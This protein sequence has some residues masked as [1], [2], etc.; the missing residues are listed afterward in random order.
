MLDRRAD[1]IVSGGENVSPAEVEAV[2]REHPDVADLGVA[3][4]PDPD[5]GSRVAA[6]IV[7][8]AGAPRRAEDLERFCRRRL[9]GFKVP[10]EFHFGDALPRNSSGKL[11]RRQLPRLGWEEPTPQPDPD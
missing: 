3:A 1:L 11:L 4:L 6:W 8:R 5:L 7:P 2:L 9:A 10:R